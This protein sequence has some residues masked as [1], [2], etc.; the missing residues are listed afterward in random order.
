MS[1]ESELK[2]IIKDLKNNLEFQKAMGVTRVPVTKEAGQ[3]PTAKATGTEPAKTQA[4][5][6]ITPEKKDDVIRIEEQI[7][8]FDAS[9]KKMTL[10]EI[11][12]EIGDCTRCKLHEGRTN[13]VFGEGNPRARLVFIGEGPGRDEDL[14]GRPFVG[15]SGQLLTKIIEAMGL[16]RED[17]YICNVVKCRPPDN[18]TP[19]PDEMATCEQF[20]FKQIRAIEPGVVVCL[21]STAAQSILK[22]KQSL[23]SLRGKFHQYGR[24]KL[25]VTYHPAALLRNP[26][27][28]KPLWD[29][30]QVVMKELGISKPGD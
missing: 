25:M 7:G 20:L 15:R 13:L 23:T 21:G 2:A 12:A 19:E 29:D 5:T 1:R 17:V 4:K 16:K 26:N 8:I 30:M 10:E 11:R 9:A 24:A 6:E 18:R 27:F 22:T 3:E 14:Q 28:K